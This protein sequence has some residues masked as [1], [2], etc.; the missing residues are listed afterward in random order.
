[1]KATKLETLE[2]QIHQEGQLLEKIDLSNSN[3]TEF[4]LDLL[5]PCKDSIKFINLGGNSLSTLPDEIQLFKNLRIL[6]FAD[7]KFRSIPKALGSISSLYMLSFKNNLLEDVPEESLSPSLHWLIL[8]NNQIKKLP[9]SIG[10]LKFL[11]KFL[12]SG[13][14]L[15][16]LPEEM[17]GCTDLELIRLSVNKLQSLPSWL[18]RLPK[19]SWI[20]FSSNNFPQVSS[21]SVSSLNIKWSSLSV[22]EKLGEGASGDIFKGKMVSDDGKKDHFVLFHPIVV[23]LLGSVVEVAVKIFKNAS[24]NSDGSAEDEIRVSC[25]YHQFILC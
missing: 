12:L 18:L 15:D 11:R 19:L 7:N 24:V 17:S 10:K 21:S 25:H 22:G 14:Q 5:L 6:F 13:N 8:T 3:L 20:A 1:M 9:S 4:P 2:R 23:S 16:S